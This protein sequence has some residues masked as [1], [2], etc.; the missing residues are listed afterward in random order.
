[1][2]RQYDNT[3]IGGT[4]RHFPA[5]EWTRLLDPKQCEALM[6]ELYQKYW[7]PLYSFLRC[8]GFSNEQAKDLVQGF[9]TE[10]VIGQE[11]V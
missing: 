9:F 10:Q 5:T 1:M 3:S 2:A 11:L 4:D 7:K 6:A 8:R